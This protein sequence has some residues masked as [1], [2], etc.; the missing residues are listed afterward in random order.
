MSDVALKIQGME[1]VLKKLVILVDTHASSG[2][3]P[4]KPRKRRQSYWTEIR[5]MISELATSVQNL[6]EKVE[7][8]V[9]ATSQNGIAGAGDHNATLEA[10]LP[11]SAQSPHERLQVD[12]NPSDTQQGPQNGESIAV[13]PSAKADH[14]TK[15]TSQLSESATDENHAHLTIPD[16]FRAGLT[17]ADQ[18]A[19]VSWPR[20]DAA[21][22]VAVPHC[23]RPPVTST[24]SQPDY[25]TPALSQ[26]P[27]NYDIT[28]P[29]RKEHGVIVLMPLNMDQCRDTPFL[30]SQAEALGARETGVFKYV[31][32][33]D[34]EPGTH[35]VSS[36]TTRIS[37]F[38]SRLGPDNIFRISRTEDPGTLHISNATF[39]PMEPDE[40]A[41]MVERRLT[42]PEAMSKIR[43]C[44]DLPARTAEDRRLLSLPAESPIWP[45]KDNLLDRTKY[46]VPGLHWPYGYVSSDDGSLFVIHHEDGNLP[47]L[48]ALHCGREKL[49][50]VVARKDGSL[51]ENEVKQGKCAQKVRHA[52]RWIPRSKLKAMGAS[53]VTFV[54]RTREVV[55][56]WGDSYHQG[57]TVGPTVAEAVNYGSPNWSIEGYSACSP[58]CDGFP[59]PSTFLE[60]RDPSEPQR[61]QEAESAPEAH[62][63]PVSGRRQRQVRNGPSQAGEAV[64]IGHLVARSLRKRRRDQS[65]TRMASGKRSRSTQSS[66][67]TMMIA[68][69]NIWYAPISQMAKAIC[70][71]AAIKQFF[72]IVRGRR[73][74]E[75]TALRMYPGKDVSRSHNPTQM[76]QNDIAA[77]NVFSKKGAF[78][79]F[80]IRL[81]Q[82]RLAQHAEEVKRSREKETGQSRE[83]IPK[84]GIQKILQGREMD[85]RQFY[86][87]RERGAKWRTYSEMFP[88]ILAFL[89]FQ[90][91]AFEFSS[92]DWVLLKDT[93]FDSLRRHLDTKQI[94][95]L[96]SAG[97]KFE[98]SLNLTAD[99]VEFAGE[100]VSLDK[101]SVE[102]LF[103]YLEPV[104]TIDE[105]EFLEN[106]YPNWRRPKYWPED[107]PWPVDPTYIPPSERQCDLCDESKCDCVNRRPEILPRI[108]IYPDKG[109][110]LQAVAKE[111]GHI[112]YLKGTHLGY[113]TGKL[114]PPDTYKNGK[115]YAM[116]REDLD[117]HPEVAQINCGERSNI[118]G[119]MNHDCV[120]TAK[121]QGQRVSGRYRVSV[122]ATRDVRDAEELTINYGNGFWGEGKQC[123]CPKCHA[124][125]I[126]TPA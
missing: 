26:T 119:Y 53:F 84:G 120:P 80:L 85:P 115:C 93:D 52:S 63:L 14:Q 74:L 39:A 44:T 92:T 71:R 42:D 97:Q 46:S 104:P 65:P 68:N 20:E 100:S 17:T 87:H 34:F 5:S 60:F 40:L 66:A 25:S 3:R 54:Q 83:R 118:Y 15:S 36:I 48:N 81:Y 58:N 77:I 61:E 1:E 38:E 33:D 99:D 113:L 116:F 69:H 107:Y 86:H 4:S 43:Y 29:H 32:P 105:N 78:H 57:G 56:V 8:S 91:Q 89:L 21:A 11:T 7:G 9:I 51:I 110:G 90:T 27:R 106:E 24:P 95:A 123:P 47:S 125:A 18:S 23:S 96:C 19:E 79:D 13:D 28:I 6:K 22:S 76:L 37:S 111:A 55:V 102:D 103:F 117:E 41:E 88:G 98:A 59:I 10:R 35:A 2:R 30:F 109:R 121:L 16:H 124:R 122:V 75:P 62:D 31:L 49:W 70:S 114:V 45:L 64:N 94:S 82:A 67:D 112:A 126:T 108:R 73:D 12:Q 101:V 72:E 50:Y